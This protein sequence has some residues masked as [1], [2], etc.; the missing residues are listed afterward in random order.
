MENQ[1]ENENEN[2]NANANGNENR[3]NGMRYFF[4]CGNMEICNTLT[5]TVTITVSGSQWK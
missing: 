3:V 1:S 4:S 5:V 2:E